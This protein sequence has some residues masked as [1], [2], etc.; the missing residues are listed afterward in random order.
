MIKCLRCVKAFQG[1][2]RPK[3]MREPLEITLKQRMQNM[4]QI[5]NKNISTRSNLHFDTFIVYAKVHTFSAAGASPSKNKHTFF[6]VRV[7]RLHIMRRTRFGF[8]HS[9]ETS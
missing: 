3:P 8:Q 1:P 2:R 6:Y 5:E 7:W 4:S 9:F